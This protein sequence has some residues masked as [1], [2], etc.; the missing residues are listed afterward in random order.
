MK[1]DR[2]EHDDGVPIRASSYQS[3]YAHSA[4]IQHIEYSPLTDVFFSLDSLGEAKCWSKLPRGG[5]FFMH[6]YPNVQCVK[7]SSRGESV[8][9]VN[10]LGTSISVYS[11]PLME[12]LR[13]VRTESLK[14]TDPNLIWFT[15]EKLFVYS[16]DLTSCVIADLC[17]VSEALIHRRST[18]VALKTVFPFLDLTKAVGVDGN[19]VLHYVHPTSDSSFTPNYPGDL[20]K[21]KASATDLY[22]FAKKK[23]VVEEIKWNSSGYLFAVRCACFGCVFEYGSGKARWKH[24]FDATDPVGDLLVDDVGR[25]AIALRSRTGVIE[26]FDIGASDQSEGAI[27]RLNNPVGGT[28]TSLKRLCYLQRPVIGKS[29]HQEVL[30]EQSYSIVVGQE[31]IEPVLLAVSNA[32]TFYLFYNTQESVGQG[33]VRHV[34]HEATHTKMIDTETSETLE[35]NQNQQQISQPQRKT[36]S[37]PKRIVIHTTLGDIIV[38]LYVDLCPKACENFFRLATERRYYNGLTFHR[39]IRGFMIQGGCPNGDGTGG[40]SIWGAT[41][42][43]EIHLPTLNHSQPFTLSMANKGPNTNGSQFFITTGPAKHLDGKHT[44]FGKVVHGFDTVRSI[45]L[46]DVNPDTH[47]PF[48]S[49]KILSCDAIKEL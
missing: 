2:P 12:R 3:S 46:C 45:E 26:F 18:G 5:I 48:S 8:V 24:E 4:N 31:Y 30:K 7:I 34:P 36:S 29:W 37:I 11:L 27:V 49:I 21:T 19:Y 22:F 17:S 23:L 38:E 6:S 47:R 25:Y 13:T 35:G 44:L 20:L 41:F 10:T 42:A 33:G 15:D 40:D 32:N 14:A 1:R 16:F 39:I 28:M 43:D 9:I